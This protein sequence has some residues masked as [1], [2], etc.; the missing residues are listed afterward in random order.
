MHVTSMHYAFLT[1]KSVTKHT[2]LGHRVLTI[3]QRHHERMIREATEIA[4]K[5]AK[6]KEDAEKLAE[7]RRLAAIRV[8][9]HP[10][11]SESGAE[12][13]DAM[14]EAVQDVINTTAAAFEVAL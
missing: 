1:S 12:I 6:A 4:T 8:P 10:V 7:E 13:L 14:P 9:M 5:R 2:T 3:A 11:A